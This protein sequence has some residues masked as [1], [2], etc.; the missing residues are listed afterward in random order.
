MTLTLEDGILFFELMWKL[1]YY[2]NQKLGLLKNISSLEEYASL[3]TKKK[4]KVRDALWEH[5][6]LFAA[7][8]DENPNDLDQNNLEIIR[9]WQKF[10]KGTFYIFR[11]L[12]KGSIFIG[13]KDT[14]YAVHGI[15]DSLEEIL[16]GYALPQMVEA[17]LLPFKGQI[18][19]DGILSGYNIIIGGGIRSDLKYT[20]T[21]A[22]NKGR[23]TTTLEPELLSTRPAKPKK[24]FLPRLK[25]ISASVTALKGDTPIQNAALTLV[26]LGLD[27]VISDAQNVLIS[28]DEI[29]TQARKIQKSSNRLLK[30]LDIMAEE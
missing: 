5:P 3:P 27:L 8:V 19:Y 9:K 13:G 28:P 22:K 26:R 16:P 2:V 29:D 14:V 23:I 18:I 25:E 10:I 6:E 20:Y 15:Q 24:L 21:V 4:L 11:H 7:Y 12:K 17:I 1:Q 30:L